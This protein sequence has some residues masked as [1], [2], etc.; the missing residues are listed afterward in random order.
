VMF[1]WTPKKAPFD[2]HPRRGQVAVMTL[3][4]D[5]DAK[6]HPKSAGACD[7]D[8]KNASDAERVRMMQNLIND[9]KDDLVDMPSIRAALN[10]VDEFRRYPFK[11]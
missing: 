9:M 3:P 8:W 11:F 7:L 4:Q 6:Q 2:Y 10:Q 5:S 1:I